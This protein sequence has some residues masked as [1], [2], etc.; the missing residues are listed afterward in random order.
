MFCWATSKQKASEWSTS[1]AL[2]G[3]IIF[4]D[5][6]SALVQI[7]INQS[8]VTACDNKPQHKDVESY[9]ADSLAKVW[10]NFREIFLV[11]H[12]KVSINKV[13]SSFDFLSVTNCFM[14]NFTNP[15]NSLTVTNAIKTSLWAT[16]FWAVQLDEYALRWG[17][18]IWD[19]LAIWAN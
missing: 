4:C 12:E 18:W 6:C 19:L 13:F 7:S 10:R 16:C 1:R 15:F 9:S 5:L 11:F 8:G 17:M 2:K 14:A 3:E